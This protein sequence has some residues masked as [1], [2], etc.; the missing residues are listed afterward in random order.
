MFFG[1]GL[2]EEE[3]ACCVRSVQFKLATWGCFRIW[4]STKLVILLLK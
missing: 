2:E 4:A 1:F 3:E